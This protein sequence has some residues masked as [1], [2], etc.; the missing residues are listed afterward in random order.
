MQTDWVARTA[1]RDEMWCKHVIAGRIAKAKLAIVVFAPTF[2]AII[3][4]KST[5]SCIT[6]GHT[7]GG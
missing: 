1:K 6:N 2:H 7:D 5:C 4:E 3:A